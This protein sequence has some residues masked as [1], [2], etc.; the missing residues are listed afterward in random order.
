M[1]I[2]TEIVEFSAKRSH[3][4]HLRDS[5][6]NLG[7]WNVASQLNFPT[8]AFIQSHFATLTID[9]IQATNLFA[10]TILLTFAPA[11]F[12]PIFCSWGDVDAHCATTPGVDVMITQ[13]SAIF[14][15]FLLK[16]W[17]FT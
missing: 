5:N 11:G 8:Q 12:D 1:R 17:R 13:F 16:I 4:V 14:V 9:A 2:E 15:N 6:R 10:V 7:S 3:F